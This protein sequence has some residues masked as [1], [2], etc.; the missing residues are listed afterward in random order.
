[1][2]PALV[3]QR[4][5]VSGG[6]E[7]VITWDDGTEST[8]AASQLRAACQCADCREPA[9][10]KR[11]EA[12]LAGSEPVT[13]AEAMLVGSYAINFVF[14]PDGHSTGIFPFPGLHALAEHADE[15]LR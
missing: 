12:V 7:V 13:I 11:T 14:G 15:E 3:P 1:V 2:D 8:Y 9:G 10:Q 5:E 4:I 6:T